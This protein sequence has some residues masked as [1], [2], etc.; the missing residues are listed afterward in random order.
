V[1]IVPF[2]GKILVLKFKKICNSGID[3]HLREG[4]RF[5]GKLEPSAL[6]M[7]LIDVKIAEG[8]DK[9]ERLQPGNLRDHH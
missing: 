3:F 9:F 4:A 2:E 7:I 1:R 6:K 8:V 5:S